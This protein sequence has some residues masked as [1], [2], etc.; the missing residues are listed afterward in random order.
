M[1]GK[2]DTSSSM[3]GPGTA[4]WVKWLG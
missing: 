1:T 4:E 2:F 3:I